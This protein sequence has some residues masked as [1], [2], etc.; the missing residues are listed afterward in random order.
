MKMNPQ[1]KEQKINPFL[2]KIS[3]KILP[4]FIFKYLDPF[5]YNIQIE[6]KKLSERYNFEGMNILD[7]GCGENKLKDKFPR[8]NFIGIDMGVGDKSWNYGKID[9]QGDLKQLPFKD[10]SFDLVISI[11]TLEHIDNPLVA[12]KEISRILK[13]GGKLF[14]IIPFMWEYHQI[15]NDFFRFTKSG[16]KVLLKE[17]KLK[18]EY[19][20]PIGG[21]FWLFSRRLFN[22]LTFFQKSIFWILFLI[23]LP[24]PILLSPI[25]YYM[26]K[27]DKSKNF[28]L[29]FK[30]KAIK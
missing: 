27:F 25:L 16:A 12:L 8:A 5:L 9:I 2:K 1:Q 3:L 20:E 21:F 10:N 14:L 15:P 22:L 30:I 29:G 6:I 19:I 28:T 24:V 17:S 11:V 4:R 7:A 23:F 26:D 13:K 18:I